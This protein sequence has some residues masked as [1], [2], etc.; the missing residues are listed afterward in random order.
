[1][2]A[3]IEITDWALPELE[4]FAHLTEAQLRN[5][6][7]GKGALYRGEPQGDYVRS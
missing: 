2:A 6:G 7:A 1:M 5:R 3:I 4:V